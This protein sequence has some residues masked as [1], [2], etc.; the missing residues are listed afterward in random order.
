MDHNCIGRIHI[1]LCVY[2]KIE[3]IGY[4]LEFSADSI[5]YIAFI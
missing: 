4:K 3:L 2:R 5:Y 1:P